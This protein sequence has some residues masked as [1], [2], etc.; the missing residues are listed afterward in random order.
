[1]KIINKPLF[2]M[3]YKTMVWSPCTRFINIA[4]SSHPPELYR[5]GNSIFQSTFENRQNMIT[6]AN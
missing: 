1:M 4:V 2:K 3:R 5:A 6:N